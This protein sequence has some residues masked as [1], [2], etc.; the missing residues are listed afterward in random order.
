MMEVFT[1]KST[2]VQC[3]FI[4]EQYTVIVLI[5]YKFH[6][7]KSKYVLVIDTC[8]FFFLVFFLFLVVGGALHFTLFSNTVF[9][10]FLVIGGALHFSLYSTVSFLFDG[11]F[12]T[13]FPTAS[14]MLIYHFC[15]LV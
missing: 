2:S 8:F 9:F 3:N 6:N 11:I 12:L 4:F 14:F 15:D 13:D 7:T 5:F 1:Q 10:L